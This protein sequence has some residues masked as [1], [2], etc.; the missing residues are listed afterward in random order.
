MLN[1]SRD[2]SARHVPYWGGGR[3][4]Y[5]VTP[6]SGPRLGG[7][8]TRKGEHSEWDGNKMNNKIKS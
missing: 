5:Y 6:G 4:A 2:K 3:R 1:P 7:S 8:R